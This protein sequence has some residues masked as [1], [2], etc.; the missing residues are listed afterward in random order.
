M[1]AQLLPIT[2]HHGTVLLVVECFGRG[3]L[4]DEKKR[5]K[6]KMA[7]TKAKSSL[8]NKIFSPF[9]E[10]QIPENNFEVKFLI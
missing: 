8:K 3:W 1:A 2:K 10:I 4:H 9:S 6:L 5:I 7:L